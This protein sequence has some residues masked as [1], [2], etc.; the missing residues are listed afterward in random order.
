MVSNYDELLTAYSK[1]QLET[2][3]AV[4][5]ITQQIGNTIL[6]KIAAAVPTSKFVYTTGSEGANNSPLKNQGRK[7]VSYSD[8]LSIAQKFN[9]DNLPAEGRYIVMEP[10]LY[11][12]LLSDPAVISFL[13]FGEATLPTGVVREVGGINIIVKPSVAIASSSGTVNA[14]GDT[15]LATDNFAALAFHTECLVRGD[16]GPIVFT[17]AGNA[18]KRGNICNITWFLSVVNPRQGLDDAGVYLLV[19]D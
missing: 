6:N 11:R 1:L 19:Q 10:Q 14:I 3:M 8:I 5:Q 4:K 17:E 2:N 16:S 12:E 15:T 18:F 13:N 7:K 9:E